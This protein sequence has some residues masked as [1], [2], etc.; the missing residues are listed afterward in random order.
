MYLLLPDCPPFTFGAQCDK[1][2][3]CDQNKSIS[4]D[5]DTGGCLCKNGW[6]GVKC[7]CEEKTECDAHSFCDANTCFCND[8][9]FIKPTNC[10][11]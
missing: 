5:T 8:G 7:T 10:S 2:C 6:S 1:S 3:A 4:C 11:G 9:V